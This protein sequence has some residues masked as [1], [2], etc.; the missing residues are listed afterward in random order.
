[1]DVEHVRMGEVAVSGTAGDE[2]VAVG[3][4]SCVGLAILDRE[5][6]VAGLAHVVLPESLGRPGPAGRFADLAVPDLIARLSERGAARRHLEAVLIGGARMFTVGASLDIGARNTDALR[7]A[8][9]SEGVPV[10]A[11]EVGG[12]RGRTAR[13]IVAEAVTSQPAG[14]QRTSLLP[15]NGRMLLQRDRVGDQL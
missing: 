11:Q 6:G 10:T 3:L 13:V 7:R 1:M 8:L 15:D 14:G 9:L 5:A 12:T 2:L 4:G